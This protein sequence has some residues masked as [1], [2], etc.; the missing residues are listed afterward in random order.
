MMNKFCIFILFFVSLFSLGTSLRCYTGFSI[1]RGQT[2]GTT[3]ENC[4][5]PDDYCYRANADINFMSSLK[6]AGC[7]T[8]RCMLNQ[9]K[10]IKQIIA[11]SE[12]EFCCCNQRDLCNFSM[13]FLNLNKFFIVIT[14]FLNIIFF[15]CL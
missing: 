14:A 3:I 8:L 12:V 15:K 13:P 6:K 1:I 10:C 2:V 9:N 5:S 4:T 7:S 11:G